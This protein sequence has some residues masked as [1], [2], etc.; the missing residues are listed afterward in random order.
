[1]QQEQASRPCPGRCSEQ[2]HGY[3]THSL[4]NPATLAEQSLVLP[5]CRAPDWAAPVAC[6]GGTPATVAEGARNYGYRR[7]SSASTLGACSTLEVRAG[8]QQGTASLGQ[9][10]LRDGCWPCAPQR[11]ATQDLQSV[12]SH[13][14]PSSAIVYAKMPSKRAAIY[15]SLVLCSRFPQRSRRCWGFLPRQ[16]TAER[17]RVPL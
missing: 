15:C 12:M 5:P 3:S 14:A 9:W 7:H 17:R 11:R 2:Q 10:R 8:G 16:A 4:K 6:G 13:G 1:M